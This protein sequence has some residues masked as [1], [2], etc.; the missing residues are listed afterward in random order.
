MYIVYQHFYQAVLDFAY[1]L[2]EN[3]GGL[4]ETGHREIFT[5]TVNQFKPNSCPEPSAILQRCMIYSICQFL[6]TGPDD[7][8][9]HLFPL[10]YLSC[11]MDCWK[12]FTLSHV[13]VEHAGLLWVTV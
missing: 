8:F 2:K 4:Q 10:Q 6:L 12:D 13:D 11:Q 1:K 7:I 5:V 9:M 3:V